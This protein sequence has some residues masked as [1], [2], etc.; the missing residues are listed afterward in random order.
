MSRRRGACLSPTPVCPAHHNHEPS[1]CLHGTTPVPIQHLFATNSVLEIE[2]LHLPCAATPESKRA[3]V[4]LRLK[5]LCNSSMQQFAT[6]LYSKS[7]K[8]Y[9]FRPIFFEHTAAHCNT[10]HQTFLA[11]SLQTCSRINFKNCFHF[12]LFTCS[13][14]SSVLQCDAVC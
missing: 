1:V 14:C 5:F 2:I 4:Y 11:T 6:I 8:V 3:L 10:L 7:R 9:L 13:V 12:H